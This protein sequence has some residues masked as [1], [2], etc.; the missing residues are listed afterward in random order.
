MA[1]RTID[2]P[3]IQRLFARLIELLGSGDEGTDANDDDSGA[4]RRVRHLDC[5]ETYA[6]SLLRHQATELE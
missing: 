2:D 1:K 5:S 3:E 6:S 4:R